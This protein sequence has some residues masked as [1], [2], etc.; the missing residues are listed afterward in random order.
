M[1]TFLITFGLIFLVCVVS[2]GFTLRVV[3]FG[4]LVCVV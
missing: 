1:L 3:L 2:F 4:F